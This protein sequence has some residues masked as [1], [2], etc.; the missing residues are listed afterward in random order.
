LSGGEDLGWGS[1][2]RKDILARIIPGVDSLL[3]QINPDDANV[4]LL[5]T[6]LII[7]LLSSIWFSSKGL[8]K[9]IDSQSTIYE[10]TEQTNF[11]IKRLRSVMMVPIISVFFIISLLSLIPLVDFYQKQWPGLVPESGVY[12]WQYEAL[13]YNTLIIYLIFWSYL[14]VGLLF[15]FSP[16]F[17]LRW[18]EISPGI[19]ITIIPTVIFI[20]LFGFLSAL[21]DYS[22]YG[23]IGTFLYSITFVLVLSYF[24]YAGIIVN[25]SYYKTFFSQR[26]VPKK[27][28]F[29]NIVLDK[30]DIFRRGR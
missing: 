24:L 7:L 15:R 8:S 16:L 20:M 22:K 19:L 12:G 4:I 1:I 14:G 3:I 11:I 2:L 17:K 5:N 26:I 9:F 10:H 6:G 23:T 30:L 21:I 13:F 27:W 29:T 25:A 18:K 28:F